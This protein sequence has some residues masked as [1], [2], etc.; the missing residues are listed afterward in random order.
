M[1]GIGSHN[2]VSIDQNARGLTLRRA[3]SFSRSV[4]GRRILLLTSRGQG[5]TSTVLRH[6]QTCERFSELLVVLGPCACVVR[7]LRHGDLRCVTRRRSRP[8]RR[9]L[10]ARLQPALNISFLEDKDARL[11]ANHL[12]LPAEDRFPNGIAREAGTPRNVDSG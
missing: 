11:G 10:Q 7:I 3:F 6:Q 1:V 2:P 9:L 12:Q 5:L 8:S 4:I